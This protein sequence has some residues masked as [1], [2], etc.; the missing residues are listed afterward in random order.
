MPSPMTI[1][2]GVAIAW[3]SWIGSSAQADEWPQWRG[4]G[5]QGYAETA[6]DLP[7]TWSETEHVVWKTPLP[8]RGWSSPVL[9]DRHL[10]MTAAFETTATDAE[11]AERLAA[12]M[13]KQPVEVAGSV[14]MHALAVD[15]DSGRLVH[16][17]TLFTVEKPQPIHKL[18]SYASPSPVLAGGR[19]FCHFG[20]YGT[21]CVDTS[22][23]TVLWVKR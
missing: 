13:N 2:L 3:A 6:R 8:G 12:S 18:N 22:A 1:A 7:V 9:D 11:K 14:T 10:W 16:D 15:R 17:V 5:G 4:P 19:L 21:A 20:D 23:A